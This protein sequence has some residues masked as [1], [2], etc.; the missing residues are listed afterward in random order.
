MSNRYSLS[1]LPDGGT[2][3]ALGDALLYFSL[4]NLTTMGYGDIV[5]VSGL[6]WPLAALEAVLGTLYLTV[7]VARLVG[8]H[9]A[10]SILGE[11][12]GS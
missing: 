10:A 1:R 6:A 2:S 7:I 5:P 8:L 3:E 11:D 12:D 9:I 4:L